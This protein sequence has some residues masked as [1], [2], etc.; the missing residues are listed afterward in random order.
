MTLGRAV[1]CAAAVIDLACM[2]VIWW[3][4][5]QLGWLLGPMQWPAGPVWPA[6]RAVTG[7]PLITAA[8]AALRNL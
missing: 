2:P 6:G 7:D 8:A 3:S 5:T 4:R 1:A